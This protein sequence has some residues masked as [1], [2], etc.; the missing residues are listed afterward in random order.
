MPE[1]SA[2]VKVLIYHLERARKLTGDGK[3]Y[4]SLNQFANA[5]FDNLLTKMEAKKQ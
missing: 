2:P 1:K 5:A 4:P 3:P